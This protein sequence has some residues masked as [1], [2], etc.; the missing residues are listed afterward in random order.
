VTPIRRREALA[1]IAIL[2]MA[3]IALAHGW[4]AQDHYAEA[5]EHGE[6]GM[7][8]EAAALVSI[9]RALLVSA[10]AGLA[11]AGWG[12]YVQRTKATL[13]AWTAVSLIAYGVMVA[14][15]IASRSSV[16]LLGH[17]DD[18]GPLWA[19]V[20]AAE[21]VTMVLVAAY[22]AGTEPRPVRQLYPREAVQTQ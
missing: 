2:A 21:I 13:G 22:A 3:G 4:A 15:G 5:A 6:M 11:I 18:A 8:D 1:T 19:V 17:T 12:V 7:A 14:A 9:A 20:V 16:G 10:I